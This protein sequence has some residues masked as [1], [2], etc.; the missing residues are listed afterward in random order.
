M[1]ERERESILET[2][3][4]FSA[5]QYIIMKEKNRFAR[6]KGKKFDTG[7]WGEFN[8]PLFLLYIHL[9]KDI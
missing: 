7:G 5:V 4:N 3:E 9:Y 6:E 1:R 8:S 2:A